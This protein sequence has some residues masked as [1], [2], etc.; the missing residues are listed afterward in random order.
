MYFAIGI[1][2]TFFGFGLC[3]LQAVEKFLESSKISYPPALFYLFN[4][5]IFLETGFI[6]SEIPLHHPE[7]VFLMLTSI[8]IIGPLNLIYYYKLLYPLQD[9]PYR[10]WIH[11][12]PAMIIFLT[13]VLFQLQPDVY[14]RDFIR[15]F[16]ED[17]LHHFM[18]IPL[19]VSALYVL[20]YIIYILK[21]FFIDLGFTKS[22]KEFQ[23]IG[24]VVILII[25]VVTALFGGIILSLPNLFISGSILNVFIH[26]CLYLSMRLF[27]QFF[28]S[29]KKE[30]RKKRYEKS[31][32][33]GIDIH[34]IQY[35]LMELMNEEWLY[36]DSEISL[37]SMARRLSLTQHQLS[38]LLNEQI[39]LGFHD[40]V[41]T[42]RIKEAQ[43]LLRENRDSNIITICFMVGFN[44][45]SSFNNAFKK[46]TGMTP[47]EF[48]QQHVQ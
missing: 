31:M 48:K 20:G 28:E 42:Y 44:S 17:P 39:G 45:K 21:L 23:I 36:R 10:M 33:G 32:L 38:Q 9:P 29:L 13:E 11:F 35:R 34:I 16:W 24:S 30:I 5:I 27:P 2:I 46:I 3:L 26:V 19:T 40:F 47:R 8:I 25:L 7:A 41:N 15:S 12:F 37:A 43:R 4:S 6:A 1:E 14:K 22:K 18:V